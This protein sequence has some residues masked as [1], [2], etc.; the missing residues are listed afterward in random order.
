MSNKTATK[1]QKK[2][3]ETD[4]E[5]AELQRQ[6]VNMAKLNLENITEIEVGSTRT[7]RHRDR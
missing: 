2:E 3:K 7:R 1:N 6:A 4:K 5:E